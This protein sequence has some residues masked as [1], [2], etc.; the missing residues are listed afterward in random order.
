L[1]AP[2]ISQEW[3][4]LELSNFQLVILVDHFVIPQATLPWQRFKVAKSAFSRTNLHSRA[5]IPKQI[6]KSQF[7][8][9][10]IV[11]NFGEIW[12]SKLRVYAVKKDTF[13][14]I[15][16][17]SAYHANISEYPGPIITNFAV[18]V[19]IWVGMI[20]SIFVWRSPKGCCYGNPLNYGDVSKHR[21]KRPLLFALPF[22]NGS[23][24]R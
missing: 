2:S 8:L 23:D 11:Y 18:L 16:Q 7:R 15:Q 14:A 10:C 24:D 19:G 9:L 20:N 3:L 12:Y 1:G 4:K 5:A 13:V 17:K 22:D 21:K 6:A